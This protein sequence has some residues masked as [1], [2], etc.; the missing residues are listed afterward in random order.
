MK[1]KIWKIGDNRVKSSK[2]S[3]KITEHLEFYIHIKWFS[4]INA[5]YFLFW[6]GSRKTEKVVVPIVTIRI[7]HIK[8]KLCFYE[9]NQLA[10]NTKNKELLIN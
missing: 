2:C 7:T 6:L 5:K 1:Q 8:S 10:K 4:K 3:K 9:F